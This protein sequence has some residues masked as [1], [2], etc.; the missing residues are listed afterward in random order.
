MEFPTSGHLLR[1][2]QPATTSTTAIDLHQSNFRPGD[3]SENG[4]SFCN[5]PA[6]PVPPPAVAKDQEC[7]ACR[8]R[9]FSIEMENEFIRSTFNSKQVQSYACR[10]EHKYATNGCIGKYSFFIKSTHKMYTIDMQTLHAFLRK[11]IC[12]QSGMQQSNSE[13]ENQATQSSLSMSISI[14]RCFSLPLV[15]VDMTRLFVLPSI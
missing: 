3:S 7:A 6:F 15:Q 9:V 5:W 2:S 11:Q 4:T 12:T 8:F 1:T 13:T 10:L 14:Q